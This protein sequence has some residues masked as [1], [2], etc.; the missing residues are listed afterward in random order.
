MMKRKAMLISILVTF[1]ASSLGTGSLCEASTEQ[2]LPVVTEN[3][4]KNQTSIADENRPNDSNANDSNEAAPDAL[5]V[6]GEMSESTCDCEVLIVNHTRH[7]IRIYVD[8]IDRGVVNP[9]SSVYCYTGAGW[10]SLYGIA[11]FRD[12]STL[13]WGPYQAYCAPFYR[14]DLYN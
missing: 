13:N 7:Q 10:T 2:K 5:K 14:W 8:G 11:Y 6:V 9:W 1:F 12:G 4:Q 3:A